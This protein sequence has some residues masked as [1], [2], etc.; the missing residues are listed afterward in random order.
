[1]EELADEVFSEYAFCIIF[2]NWILSGW[3]DPISDDED[4]D[5]EEPTYI[6]LM[7]ESKQKTMSAMKSIYDNHVN[8]TDESIAVLALKSTLDW[9]K[10]MHDEVMYRL[11]QPELRDR[12]GMGPFL[13]KM[14]FADCDRSLR[15]ACLALQNGTSEDFLE[16]L[17]HVIHIEN[18]WKLSGAE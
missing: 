18:V 12:I 10:A 16:S 8:V 4:S 15:L 6:N 5:D 7:H 14:H 9:R 13:A 2:P 3:I 17:D 1:V 11:N